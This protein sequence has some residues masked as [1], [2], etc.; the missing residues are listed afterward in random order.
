MNECNSEETYEQ[1][2]LMGAM[3]VEWKFQRR[4]RGES[5]TAA[6]NNNQEQKQ[7]KESFGRVWSME[8]GFGVPVSF[9]IVECL[10]HTRA[11]IANETGAVENFTP[12][13]FKLKK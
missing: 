3:G 8:W 2:N 6:T 12:K 10:L 1:K 11:S 7:R 9:F 4:E 13:I 5:A